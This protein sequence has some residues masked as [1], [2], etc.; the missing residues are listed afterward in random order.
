MK[1]KGLLVFLILWWA[2]ALRGQASL[3]QLS[4]LVG[5]SVCGPDLINSQPLRTR[6]R[7]V[8]GN[9]FR[10]LTSRAM[11]C[12]F[13]VDINQGLLLAPNM[14]AHWGTE[15]E[16]LIIIDTRNNTVEVKLLHRGKIY[17][18]ADP[19]HPLTPPSGWKSGAGWTDAEEAQ[20]PISKRR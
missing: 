17:T 6:L 8:M 10:Q 4:N 18:Y 11:M 14:R 12:G 20:G 16:S 3:N 15:E 13:P 2:S 5:K 1:T 7:N 19:K 9:D